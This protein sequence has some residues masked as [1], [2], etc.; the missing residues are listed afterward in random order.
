MNLRAWVGLPDGS[1]WVGDELLG[2]VYDPEAPALAA[3]CA[4]RSRDCLRG[5]APGQLLRPRPEEMAV[6]HA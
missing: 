1:A 4:R 2:G 3:R 6:E 5:P